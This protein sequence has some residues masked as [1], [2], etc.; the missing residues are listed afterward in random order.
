[1]LF[2]FAVDMKMRKILVKKGVEGHIL[3][4]FE[5]KGVTYTA[6]YVF[7]CVL[8]C[9]IFESFHISEISKY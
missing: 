4:I 2:G 7:V 6:I 9:R 5:V 3:S 1:M 8:T